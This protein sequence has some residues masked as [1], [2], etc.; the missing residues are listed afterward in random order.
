MAKIA[1][2]ASGSGS[3]FEAIA[4]ATQEGYLDCTISCLVVDKKDAYAIE[5]AKKLEIPWFLVDPKSFSNKQDY[6]KRIL[7][8]IGLKLDLIV[9]AGYMRLVGK[10]LL[11][12]YSKRIINIHPSLLPKYKGLHAFERSYNSKDELVGAT[13][14]Y[15]NEELDGGAILDQVSFKKNGLNYIEAEDK[16]H[17]EEHKLYKEVIKKILEGSYEKSTN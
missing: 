12:A 2:F 16:L 3:N 17:Q 5:R 8:L 13:A 7:E 14:H 9:L 1:I 15:V 10:T 4:L 11:E 6:E